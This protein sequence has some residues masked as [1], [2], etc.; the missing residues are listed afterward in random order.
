MRGVLH[1][2]DA[3]NRPRIPAEGVHGAG[4]DFRDG[5][6]VEDVPAEHDQRPAPFRPGVQGDLRGVQ[7]VARAVPGGFRRVAHTAGQHHRNV[8]R[9]RQVQQEGRFLQ[10]VGAVRDDHPVG[11]RRDFLDQLR[12]GQHVRGRD[13]RAGQVERLEFLHGH[14]RQ[15]GQVGRFLRRHARAVGVGAAGDGAPGV[16][17][18]EALGHEGQRTGYPWP[19]ASPRNPAAGASVRDR[20]TENVADRRKR[21]GTAVRW[22]CAVVLSART[23]TLISLS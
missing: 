20:R 4:V 11:V 18:G 2:V 21:R 3:A 14:A 10:G 22:C 23:T 17:Q 19:H 8:R 6:G 15:A 13:V 5:A 9:Q 1:P 16:N 7:Q 12:E